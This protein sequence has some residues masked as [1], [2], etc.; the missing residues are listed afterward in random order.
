M[1]MVSRSNLWTMAQK[2]SP[3]FQAVDMLV[4]LTPGYLVIIL[5][6]NCA[7]LDRF[8]DD[9]DSDMDDASYCQLSGICG[10]QAG[11]DIAHCCAIFLGNLGIEI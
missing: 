3:S 9:A 4:T 1:I 6:E 8:G 10:D 11:V 7:H 2:A 5:G